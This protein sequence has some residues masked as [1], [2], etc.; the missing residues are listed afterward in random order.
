M[1]KLS[2]FANCFDLRDFSALGCGVELAHIG[3][4]HQMLNLN[5]LPKALDKR[6]GFQNYFLEVTF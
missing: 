2:A 1:P 4:A 5:T 6:A 3:L